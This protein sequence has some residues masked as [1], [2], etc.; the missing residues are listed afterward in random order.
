MRMRASGTQLD[1][2]LIVTE[3]GVGGL[4]RSLAVGRRR[5]LRQLSSG[6]RERSS[7][8]ESL[9]GIRTAMILI[10]SQHSAIDRKCP[11]YESLSEGCQALASVRKAPPRLDT[12]I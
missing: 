11:D 2:S 8:T 10:L 3:A 6:D 5:G 4:E 7:G 12:D 9:F 1:G